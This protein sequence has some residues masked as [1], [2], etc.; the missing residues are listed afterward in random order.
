MK[1]YM[2]TTPKGINNWTGAGVSKNSLTKMTADCPSMEL[3]FNLNTSDFEIYK[4][5]NEEIKIVL[6]KKKAA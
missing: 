6:T 5:A 1:P 4:F 2:I 3:S